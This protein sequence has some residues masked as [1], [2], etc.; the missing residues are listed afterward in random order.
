MTAIRTILL[1]EDSP[2][3]AEMA[4]DALREARLANPIVHVEDGVEAM[5][6]LLRRGVFADREEGLPAV[7]LLDIKMPRLDGLEVLKQVRSDETLKRLPVVI[8][9]SSREE[10]D[11]ARSWDLGVNAYVVKPVDV[12]QFFNAV[13]TLGTFWAVINQA[14][15]LD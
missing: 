5:D 14:P 11:L 4:V 9:S 7:L 6:Y 13:K 12:D 10:S 1:A 2:A 8:L 3:D 15:E